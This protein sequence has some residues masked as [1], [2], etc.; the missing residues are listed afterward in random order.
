MSYQSTLI[1]YSNSN[2]NQSTEDLYNTANDI[3]HKDKR[4]GNVSVTL[5]DKV[6]FTPILEF[7]K[8]SSIDIG[9][10]ENNNLISINTNS[11]SDGLQFKVTERNKAFSADLIVFIF[12]MS[13][14]SC[15]SKVKGWMETIVCDGIVGDKNQ[16]FTFGPLK[17]KHSLLICNTSVKSDDFGYKGKFI[18]TV[19]E[20]FEHLTHGM[21]NYSGMNVFPS[22]FT[23]KDT[24]DYASK[25]KEYLASII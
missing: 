17:G 16:I 3:F 1:I 14:G 5:L 21:L 19:E 4:F 20:C 7:S 6:D 12:E 22:F 24:I 13:S 10:N 25:L 18:L 2:K 23:Y 9:K 15:P 11:N 8:N